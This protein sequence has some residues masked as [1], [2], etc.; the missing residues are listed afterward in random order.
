[1]LFRDQ[2]LDEYFEE[3]RQSFL[4]NESPVFTKEDLIYHQLYNGHWLTRINQTPID[5]LICKETPSMTAVTLRKSFRE[6]LSFGGTFDDAMKYFEFGVFKQH[7]FWMLWGSDDQQ[8]LACAWLKGMTQYDMYRAMNIQMTEFTYSLEQLKEYASKLPDSVFYKDA[9]VSKSGI[10]IS[11]LA[12][13]TDLG[14]A[15]FSFPVKDKR[16]QILVEETMRR[17]ISFSDVWSDRQPIWT[18][19]NIY[20]LP[21]WSTITTDVQ[22]DIF[23]K[24]V[25]HEKATP[26]KY[27]KRD[28]MKLYPPFIRKILVTIGCMFRFRRQN[29][30]FHKDLLSMLYGMVVRNAYEYNQERI[31]EV[32]SKGN[33]VYHSKMT[34]KDLRLALADRRI[35]CDG[36]STVNMSTR[37]F[38]AMNA[39]RYIASQRLVAFD[40]GILDCQ[41]REEYVN[42]IC[43][44]GHYWWTGSF[45]SVNKRQEARLLAYQCY[46]NDI[47]VSLI[48]SGKIKLDESFLIANV[49]V[50]IDKSRN[51]IKEANSFKIGLS[52][53]QQ[54]R[55]KK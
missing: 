43:D 3:I 8:S 26:I 46:D 39:V 55:L 52:K 36:K 44:G 27:N 54:K 49:P 16:C 19:N 42:A 40:A 18:F 21:I 30:N 28:V 15:S 20:T 14:N 5:T 4:S 2:R 23:L 10:F 47:T 7:P 12:L 11:H 38:P 35:G 41:S 51:H 45:L 33:I 6:S 24:A 9:D 48:R 25:F 13:A 32:A 53:P 17:G 29:F 31:G 34:M 37:L 50:A 22:F 1:M